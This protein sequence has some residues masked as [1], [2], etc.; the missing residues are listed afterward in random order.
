MK[1]WNMVPEALKH[2]LRVAVFIILSAGLTAL[3]D[4]IGKLDLSPTAAVVLT[5]LINIT[6]A[7]IKKEDDI[8]KL[9]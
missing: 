5:G 9:K 1:Y 7:A 6:I 8:R 4:N 2:S 3:L